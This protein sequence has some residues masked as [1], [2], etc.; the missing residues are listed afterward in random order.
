MH[1]RAFVGSLAHPA[2]T[3][4]AR[5]PG[6]VVANVLVVSLLAVAAE[7]LVP[8]AGS[9]LI[10]VGFALLVGRGYAI[11][12]TPWA[13]RAVERRADAL[14]TPGP[15]RIP[16]DEREL[17]RAGV[18][19]VRGDE[20]RP[21]ESFAAAWRTHVVTAGRRE[22]DARSL[23]V[24]LGLP[25]DAVRVAPVGE[26][27]VAEARERRLGAWL[28]RAA[29][30]ADTASI[31]ELRRFC[32][33][34]DL[35]SPRLRGA[36]LATLRL[37]LDVCPV[38]DGELS[39]DRATSRVP[40]AVDTVVAVTCTGCDARLFESGFVASVA[41]ADDDTSPSVVGH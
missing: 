30:V 12:G 27:L 20:F 17:L 13:L 37:Y 19:A 24:V 11:P 25:S 32:P 9:V 3:G 29:L 36:M 5:D 22:N 26:L 34:W 2:Y 1:L 38:C 18:F 15:E 40:G 4:Q 23:A 6:F 7:S 16:R 10:A 31:A 39:L 14:A 28:S 35:L 8:L 21:T 41:V 33:Q